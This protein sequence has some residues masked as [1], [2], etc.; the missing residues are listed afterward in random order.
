MAVTGFEMLPTRIIV[1]GLIAR[2]VVESANPT[3]PA[4]FKLPWAPIAKLMP[5]SSKSERALRNASCAAAGQ[6]SN[7]QEESGAEAASGAAATSKDEQELSHG[8]PG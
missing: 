4:Q 6:A 1:V 8:N 2:A 5:V 7:T 3:A